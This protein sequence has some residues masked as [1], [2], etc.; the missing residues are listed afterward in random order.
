[1]LRETKK[2]R[3]CYPTSEIDRKIGILEEFVETSKMHFEN[4]NLEDG[5]NPRSS[6]SRQ[7]LEINGYLKEIETPLNPAKKWA[8]PGSKKAKCQDHA[9]KITEFLREQANDSRYML[10]PKFHKENQKNM[11]IETCEKN[12][13]ALRCKTEYC[14]FKYHAPLLKKKKLDPQILRQTRRYMSRFTQSRDSSRTM[15]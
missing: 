1:L 13:R 7:N 5:I 12:N 6:F 4:L 9:Q 14:Q 8:I 2:V 3:K 10:I 15:F 11:E